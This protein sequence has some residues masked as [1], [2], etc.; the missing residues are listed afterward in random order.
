MAQGIKDLM[1]SLHG[2]GCCCGTG[3]ISG[4]G[5]STCHGGSLDKQ[6]NN[7][8]QAVCVRVMGVDKD[9]S[10]VNTELLNSGKKPLFF[11]TGLNPL[12]KIRIL[13]LS[14]FASLPKVL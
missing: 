6:I 10:L 1:L 8:E 11:W 14:I 3:S 9:L 4:P 5:T 13:M 2:L 12:Y 7:N